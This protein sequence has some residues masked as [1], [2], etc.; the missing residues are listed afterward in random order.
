M[1]QKFGELVSSYS[2][3]LR[4]LCAVNRMVGMQN[5]PHQRARAIGILARL[6]RT[7]AEPPNVS[8]CKATLPAE[9]FG[10]GRLKKTP[11]RPATT[12]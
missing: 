3:G 6:D 5:H 4:R 9:R 11:M 1:T 7:R 12:G 2:S 10:H 8:D